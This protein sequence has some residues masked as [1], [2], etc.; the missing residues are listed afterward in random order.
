MREIEIPIPE[1]GL[2]AITRGALGIG[3]GLL[4]ADRMNCQERRAA[5]LALVAIGVLTT[6]P[7]AIDVFGRRR[8]ARAEHQSQRQPQVA[9]PY[10]I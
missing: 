5:G 10:G 3:I 4:I 9:G 1:I 6:I 8:I 2:I 7:L